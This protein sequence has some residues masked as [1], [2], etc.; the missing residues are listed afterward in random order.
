VQDVVLALLT[1]EPSHGYE[2]RR[3]LAAAPAVAVL[4]ALP[5]RAHTRSPAGRALDAEPV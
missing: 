2:L 4:T 5:A 3:R 1:M